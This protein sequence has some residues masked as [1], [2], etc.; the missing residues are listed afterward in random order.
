MVQLRRGGA[1]RRSA[2][3]P[4][5]LLERVQAQLQLRERC[6]LLRQQRRQVGAVA[7]DVACGSGEGPG[8]VKQ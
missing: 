8:R 1:A 6:L 5:Q 3:G 4:H 7:L 2:H